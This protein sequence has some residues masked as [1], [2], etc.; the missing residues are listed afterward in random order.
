MPWD[1]QLFS[2]F[3]MLYFLEGQIALYREEGIVAYKGTNLSFIQQKNPKTIC[4]Y[5]GDFFSSLLNSLIRFTDF[6][7]VQ[8]KSFE[9]D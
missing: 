3:P 2:K 1:L 6:E 5:G 4:K 7:V 8:P 9:M